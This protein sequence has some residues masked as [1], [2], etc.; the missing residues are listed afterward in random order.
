MF[1]TYQY[2][3]RLQISVGHPII[4][5]KLEPSMK[6]KLIFEKKSSIFIA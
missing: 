4:M 5:K 2:I 3:W 1:I 6:S